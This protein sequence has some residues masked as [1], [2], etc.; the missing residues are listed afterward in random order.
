MKTVVWHK[1]DTLHIETELGIVNIRPHLQD[2]KGRAV[3][4]I[5]V[6][7]DRYAGEPKVKRSGP[8]NVRLIQL[9]K[10]R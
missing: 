6:I 5:E 2:M 9:K 3:T 7:P 1:N 10:K 4:S 8:A